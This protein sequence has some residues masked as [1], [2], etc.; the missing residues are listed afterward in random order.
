MFKKFVIID[1]SALLAVFLNEEGREDLERKTV[2]C[3]LAAPGCI[4]WEIGNALYGAYKRKRV[5]FDQAQHVFGEFI[6][7]SVRILEREVAAA[8]E[9]AMTEGIPTYDAYYLQCATQHGFPML[10]L[11]RRMAAIA[12][13]RDLIVL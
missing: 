2:G 3:L 13:N 1:P 9:I 7:L 10:T 4:Q 11:D 5:T 6:N 8:L 12:C